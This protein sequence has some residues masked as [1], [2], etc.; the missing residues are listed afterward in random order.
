MWCIRGEEDYGVIEV[1]E[2]LL[3]YND[4]G[5]HPHFSRI[6]G[7]VL[8]QPKPTDK[9]VYLWPQPAAFASHARRFDEL[10]MAGHAVEFRCGTCGM[11]CKN[12]RGLYQH[13]KNFR[14]DC[15]VED[16]QLRSMLGA[17]NHQQE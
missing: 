12:N 8:K 4:R 13:K 10:A 17:H 1:S 11:E 16:R 6:H 2:A 5:R 15:E 7:T 9:Y 3:Q 14:D